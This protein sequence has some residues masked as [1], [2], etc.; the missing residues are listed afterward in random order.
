MKIPSIDLHGKKEHEV[1]EAVDRFLFSIS[2]KSIKRA[3][4]IT[5]KGSGIVQKK[6][7][8]YLKMAAYPW[9][10]EKSITGKPN[11]GVIILLL[12]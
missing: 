3:K 7:I 2:N 6:V 1:E 10:Y 12:D 8:Q 5:G 4:I 9:E 11:T